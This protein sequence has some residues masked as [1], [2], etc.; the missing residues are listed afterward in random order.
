MRKVG[1]IWFFRWG[2]F[3]GSIYLTKGEAPFE[4]RI[5]WTS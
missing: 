1:G 2:R 3:G 5:L 4:E